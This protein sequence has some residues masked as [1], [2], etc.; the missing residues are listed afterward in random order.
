MAGA[1][2]ARTLVRVVAT[3]PLVIACAAGIALNL[4]GLPQP[5]ALGRFLEIL[6]SAALGLGLLCVGA[7]L[8]LESLV[9]DRRGI[10]IASVAKL[11]VLPLASA[12]MCHLLGVGGTGR[13]VVLLF[14][15]LPSS[16]AAYVLA[17]QMGGNATM[18]AGI[19]TVTTPGAMAAIPIVLALFG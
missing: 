7:A 18:M 4:S 15:A 9:A 16:P 1:A 8:H 13:D 3:N 5:E 12:L 10:A 14:A 6:G 2:S 19:I 17:R 11:V